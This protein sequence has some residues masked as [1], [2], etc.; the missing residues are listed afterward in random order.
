MIKS[1]QIDNNE[2]NLIDLIITIIEGRWRIFSSI[3]IVLLVVFAHQAIFGEKIKNFTVSTEI[4]PINSFEESKYLTINNYILRKYSFTDTGYQLGK[5]NNNT[6]ETQ[7]QDFSIMNLKNYM[8]II[9]KFTK[10]NFL[11][12]YIEILNEKKL[13]EEAIRKYNLIDI[14][15]YSD[16]KKYNEAVTKLASSIKIVKNFLDNKKKMTI[17]LS[18]IFNLPLM[19]VKSGKTFCNMLM[20]KQIRP[21]D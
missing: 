16:E 5:S 7:D 21:C 8:Y 11:D 4:L 10:S 9:P 18:I 12:I 6:E 2:I 13:F 17:K 1:K 15:L 14:N 19:I 3:I 20:K